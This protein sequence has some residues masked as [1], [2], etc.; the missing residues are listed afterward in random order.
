[1]GY[2]AAA[3]DSAGGGVTLFYRLQGRPDPAVMNLLRAAW[4]DQRVAEKAPPPLSLRR[5]SPFFEAPHRTPPPSSEIP[6]RASLG[7]VRHAANL[8][9]R[10]TN[11][12]VARRQSSLAARL[13]LGLPRALCARAGAA[14]SRRRRFAPGHHAGAASVFRSAGFVGGYA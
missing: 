1:M 2:G 5:R 6:P 7:A 13:S 10:R 9:F 8:S 12:C 11:V 14:D 3:F 4:A